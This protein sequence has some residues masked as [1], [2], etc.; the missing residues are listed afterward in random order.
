VRLQRVDVLGEHRL[1]DLRD[2]SLVGEV[3]A[4]DLDPGRLL[5]EEGVELLLGELRDGLSG[6]KKPQP[7]KIRPYQPSML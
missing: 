5:V 2:Q 6:S 3:D 4:V 7:P 1:R